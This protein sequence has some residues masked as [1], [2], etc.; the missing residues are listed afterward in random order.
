MRKELTDRTLL[1]AM[2]PSLH[3]IDSIESEIAASIDRF[4]DAVS[5]KLLSAIAQDTSHAEA[6]SE[7]PSPYPDNGSVTG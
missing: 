5:A 2:R 1:P 3:R 7:K 4:A 6:A